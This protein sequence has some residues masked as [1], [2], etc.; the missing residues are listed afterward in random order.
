MSFSMPIAVVYTF[1]KITKDA[2]EPAFR[3]YR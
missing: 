2:L 3:I 1:K